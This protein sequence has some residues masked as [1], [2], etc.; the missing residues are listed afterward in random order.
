MKVCLIKSANRPSLL[1]GFMYNLHMNNS[2]KEFIKLTYNKQGKALDLG[3]GEF[4]DVACLN[5]LGWK[6]DGV[7]LNTGVDLELPFLSEKTPYDLVFS[8]Y[9]IQKL[10]NKTVLIK[11]AFNNLKSGGWFF[12]HTF[13]ITDETNK[14]KRQEISEPSIKK[15]LEDVGFKNVKIRVFSFYDNDTGHKHWHQILEAVAQK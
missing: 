13:D 8:N 6:C 15:L 11:T 10:K 2:L 9:V 5:Q 1:S 3:A 4:F 14:E 12:I 7:D